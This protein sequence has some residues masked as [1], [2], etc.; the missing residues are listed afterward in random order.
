MDPNFYELFA[1]DDAS[2]AQEQAA[3]LQQLLRRNQ[4]ASTMA[5]LSGAKGMQPFAQMTGG[6]ARQQEQMLGQAGAGRLHMTLEQAKERQRQVERTDDRNWHTEQNQLNRDAITDRQNDRMG[7]KEDLSPIEP[8]LAQALGQLGLDPTLFKNRGEAMEIVKNARFYSNEL[9]NRKFGWQQTQHDEPNRAEVEKM[10]EFD[11]VLKGLDRIKADKAQ[12][13]TGPLADMQNNW[14]QKIGVA[15]PNLT[16]WK[17]EV[18]QQLADYIRSMSGKAATDFER[19]DLRRNTPVPSDQDDVF[20]AKMDRL[21]DRITQMRERERVNIQLG[22]RNMGA[23]APGGVTQGTLQQPQPQQAPAD[24]H[25]ALRA[26]Y[27]L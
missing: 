10:S 8:A 11:T 26:K 17:A 21:I 25:A 16:A 19:A 7:A 24:P 2:A 12:F 23:F 18:G 13:D 6:M 15:D 4:T 20:V 27:Q 22:G 1:T 5:A 9:A 14:A 3:A